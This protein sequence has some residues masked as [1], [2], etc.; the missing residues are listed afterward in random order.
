M[1]N[2]ENELG[3]KGFIEMNEEIRDI[4]IERRLSDRNRRELEGKRKKYLQY[5]LRCRSD[6]HKK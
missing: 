3:E 1:F 4:H 6:I 2:H 5:V